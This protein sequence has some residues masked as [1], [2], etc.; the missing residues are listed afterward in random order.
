MGLITASRLSAARACPRLHYVQYHLGYRPVV[1]DENLSFGSLMHLGFEAWWKAQPD[2]RL[3]AATLALE[4]VESDPVSLT[5]ARV[6]MAGYHFRWE[7][8]PY[9]PVTLPDGSPAVEVEFRTALVNPDTGAKSRT[10]DLAGKIDAIV[11]DTRD[12]SIYVL[13][14]K[15]S[16]ADI[17]PGSRYWERLTMDSQLSI[18]VDG[19]TALGFPPKAVI[20]DV[21]AKPGMRPLKATPEENR[22]YTKDGRLYAN[23]RAEDEPLEEYHARLT[24]YVAQHPDEVFRRGE[25]VRLER[26]LDEA[27]YDVWATARRIHEDNVAKRWPR[28][29]DACSRYGG[30]CAFFPW[31]SGTG[32]LEDASLYRRIETPHPELSEA[33]A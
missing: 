12:G 23:Q 22:K 14:H 19:A 25:V 8:E 27:R 26:E 4:I 33:A 21:V 3:L 17:S 1:A 5:R 11:R 30:M 18:Y 31:C 29:P 24:E 10:W 16:S 9:E 28:N 13:E 6:L 32:S 7:R 2:Q 20:Y 15:T